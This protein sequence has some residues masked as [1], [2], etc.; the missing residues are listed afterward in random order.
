MVILNEFKKPYEIA[1]L[2]YIL[3]ITGYRCF[4]EHTWSLIS[5]RY[6]HL[7]QDNYMHKDKSWT[8]ITHLSQKAPLNMCTQFSSNQFLYK[9]EAV[10]TSCMRRS[11][12]MRRGR[13]YENILTLSRSLYPCRNTCKMS[14]TNSRLSKAISSNKSTTVMADLYNHCQ[15]NIFSRL[16]RNSKWHKSK[17]IQDKISIQFT[18]N[19]N[20]CLP[21]IF[22]KLV[23]IM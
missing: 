8:T 14:C 18:K 12:W 13:V 6:S 19:F 17:N 4:L 16:F 15:S 22:W 5:C 21:Q 7:F 9:F 23:S 2:H 1:L 10:R 11:L 3:T 20:A